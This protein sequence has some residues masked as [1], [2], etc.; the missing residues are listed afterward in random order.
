MFVS[1]V[2]LSFFCVYLI[3]CFKNIYNK[4]YFSKER[5]NERIQIKIDNESDYT[6]N[7][8]SRSKIPSKIDV[9]VIGSGIGGLTTAGLLSK[10]GKR[11]LVLEQHYIAGGTTH[12]FLDKGVE[13]ET[14]LHYI[15]NIKKRRKVLDI[16]TYNP[17]HWCKMGWERDDNRDIYDEIYIGDNHYEFEAGEENFI[18]YLMK[19]FPH[20]DRQSFEAYIYHIKQASKKENFFLAKVLPY[21]WLSYFFAGNDYKYD[22]YCKTS[23]YNFIKQIFTDEELISV[24]LGQFGDYGVTPKKASFFLHASIVNHYIDGGWFPSGGTG[25]IANEICKTIK[26]YGGDVLVGKSVK[27]ILTSK[28]MAYGV[29]MENGDIIYC[30]NIVSGVGLRNTFESLVKV[31]DNSIYNKMLS[32]MAPSVQHIYCF[33]KLEGNPDEL[34]LR[35]SNFWIYPHGDYDKL[36]DDF[37]EDPLEAPIPLFMGFS[38][39]KDREWSKKY[40]GVSNAI[41]LTVGK[42]EWFEEWE[43]KKC[44]KRGE[45]YENFKNQLGERMLENGLFKY[46]PDLRDN[47]LDYSIG[48]PLSTQFYLNSPDGESYGLDMNSYR[49]TEAYDL[50]PKTNIEGL[51]LTGQDICTLGVT[52]AMMGGVLTANVMAGYDNLPDIIFKNNIVNDLLNKIDL[53][54]Y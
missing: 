17:I 43:D 19:R 30:N 3:S 29:E 45:A 32:K 9:I 53:K 31:P 18:N 49:L 23:A 52:G 14:G 2:L 11:V 26:S 33:V 40:P 8:Y 25:V 38:S 7:R 20:E 16:I 4:K 50:K 1:L 5:I 37:L 48:T 12:S 41:I 51:Y 10:F 35:S 42:K 27:K 22:Y 46:Y 28:N 36:I 13:H 47:L 54:N 44:M 21:K 39:M 24:L 34:K 6:K 15:G